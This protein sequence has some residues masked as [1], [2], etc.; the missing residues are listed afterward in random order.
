[1][2][3]F[4]NNKKKIL[5]FILVFGIILLIMYFTLQSKKFFFKEDLIF[6]KFLNNGN[7]ENNQKETE[8]IEKQNQ[9][10]I[11][12]KKHK[13]GYKNIDFF[14]TIDTNTLVNQKIAPGTKGDF[15]VFLT[16]NTNLEYELKIIS[17]NKKPKNFVFY[18]EEDKGKLV[19]NETKEVKI[20]WEWLYE[21]SIEDNIQDTKDGIN[22]ERYEFEICTVG[23]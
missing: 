1:M 7:L 13:R 20:C 18:I 3:E 12:V 23:K 2:I 11:E 22:I 16:S 8:K 10:Y 15:S 21:T 17:E 4:R 14:Q 19:A 6:F 5:I 9:Y